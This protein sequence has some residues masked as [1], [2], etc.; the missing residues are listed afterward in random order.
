MDTPTPGSYDLTWYTVD[1]GGGTFSQGGNFSLGGTIGQYDAGSMSGGDFVINGGFWPGVGTAGTPIPTNTP[2]ETPTDTPTDTPTGTPTDT[3]TPTPTAGVLVGH[4]IWQ[5][6]PAQPNVRQ[7]LPITLTLKLGTTEVNYT[8]QNTNS[9]GFF[10]V[11]VSSLASGTYN[12]RVKGP[13]YLANSGTV[14]LS[15]ASVTNQEMGLMKVGDCNNDNVVNVQ[16]FNILKT[17]FGKLAGDPGYD[18][19]ADF[20]GDNLVSVLD[21][22]LLKGNFGFGGVP[23]LGPRN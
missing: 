1:G 19:R 9:S 20:N 10:T 16:D 4:V 5:G 12:W 23:P 8:S 7:Q 13:K 6:P 2:T 15:G 3:A 21:F 11:S 17:T 22:N 14:I 18:G